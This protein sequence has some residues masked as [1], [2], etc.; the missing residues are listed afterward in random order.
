[1][2]AKAAMM[3]LA[4]G[5]MLSACA[6]EVSVP[7]TGQF[8]NGTPA[9]GQATARLDGNGTFWIQAPGSTRCEGRYNSLDS[10]PSIIVPVDCSGGATGE[11]VI[12]R[13][14]TGTG[15]TA[16][17]KLSNGQTG[18]FVFGDLTYAQAFGSGGQ[19]SIR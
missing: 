9:S 12:T 10:N 13:Q 5:M 8:G 16:I 14:M 17:A 7:V 1:M 11:V 4:A 2:T 3:A 15:G 6:T 19:A 18:Q